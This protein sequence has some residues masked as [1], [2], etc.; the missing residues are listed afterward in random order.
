M[1]EDAL[2]EDDFAARRVAREATATTTATRRSRRPPTRSVCA[3]LD[4]TS[5]SSEEKRRRT[6]RGLRR[7][8]TRTTSETWTATTGWRTG[9]RTRRWPSRAACAGRLRTASSRSTL[10]AD[11][12]VEDEDD[13]DTAGDAWRDVRRG[14]KLSVTGMALTSD[15]STCYT[16]SKDGG[17][18]KW[19]IETGARTRFPRAP[20]GCRPEPRRR[21]T[22]GAAEAAPRRCCAA[23][24]P[25]STTCCTAGADK[26]IHVWDTRTAKK[27]HEFASHRGAVTGLAI[28]DGTGQMFSSSTDKTLKV[29][30]LDDM[31]YVDTLFGHQSDVLGVSRSARSAW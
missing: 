29:W 22:D 12:D 31:A 26:R 18:A 13:E 21:R 16:V 7:R 9:S 20:R 5:R 11:S 1:L 17:I 19:D 2:D 4:P 25:R 28:R 27:V 3:W 14:H 23:R 30:S 8:T 6:G 15:D 10:D 24:C